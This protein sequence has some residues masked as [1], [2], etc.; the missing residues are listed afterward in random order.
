MLDAATHPGVAT[1]ATASFRA[2]SE[3]PCGRM[4]PAPYWA[5]CYTNPQAE[6]WAASQLQR[7]GYR[8]LLPLL[9]VR[10]RDRVVRS[11][12][13]TVEIPL[14]SRYLF[15]HLDGNWAPICATPGV[16]SLL[17]DGT[18]PGRVS[19]AAVSALQA[20]EALRRIPT[21]GEPLWR[22][23]VAC[24]ARLGG[25]QTVQGIVISVRRQKATVAAIMFGAL[26]ELTVAV[27]NLQPRTKED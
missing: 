9:A 16:R 20:S 26:R 11:L 6:R 24:E 8:V 21:P 27:R 14:F 12:W 10:R 17:T 3:L 25:G 7:A 13:T 22:P 23:G 2:R 5:V 18:K 15:V 4:P 19:E 1:P